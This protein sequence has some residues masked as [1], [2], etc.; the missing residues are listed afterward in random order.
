[1]MTKVD[2][3]RADLGYEGIESINVSS[4][5]QRRHCCKKATIL[6]RQSEGLLGKTCSIVNLF[7]VVHK[8]QHK[9]AKKTQKIL[10]PCPD[11]LRDSSN[12]SLK[13]WGF[14]V[15]ESHERTQFQPNRANG[16]LKRMC[17]MSSTTPQRVQAG[18]ALPCRLMIWSL[19][20]SLR[21]RACHRKILI[22]RGIRACHSPLKRSSVLPGMSLL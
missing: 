12:R 18:L 4:F 3:S 16:K 22:F 11:R 20:G 14:Q 17:S 7:L 5:K 13:L 21:L 19:A 6:N 9:A 15:H 1:M 8:L 2:G 10:R